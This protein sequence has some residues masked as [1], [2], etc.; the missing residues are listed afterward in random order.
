MGRNSN[1]PASSG[2]PPAGQ[3]KIENIII[4]AP[5]RIQGDLM[6]NWLRHEFKIPNVVTTYT[7]AQALSKLHEAPQS[8]FIFDIFSGNYAGINL[9]I[10]IKDQLPAVSIISI[11]AYSHFIFPQLAHKFGILAYMPQSGGLQSLSTILKAIKDGHQPQ[12]TIE[13]K[14]Y[15]QAQHQ[16]IEFLQEFKPSTL[17]IWALTVQGKTIKQTADLVSLSVPCIKT[18]RKTIREKLD[19][20][21][22]DLII[23][24]AKSFQ[25]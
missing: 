24:Q 22:L 15:T 10:K 1:N 2:Q 23:E 21:D 17:Q 14:A 18:N 13:D 8:L 20:D 19:I 9:A 3:A 6:E 12:S 25:N 5:N 4:L 11:S 7:K 16:T